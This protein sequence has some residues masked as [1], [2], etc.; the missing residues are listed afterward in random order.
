MTVNNGDTA[1]TSLCFGAL[2]LRPSNGRGVTTYA[3]ELLPH[4]GP[5]VRGTSLSAVVQADAASEL[6]PNIR[7]EVRPVSTGAKRTWQRFTT[8]ARV[9]VFHGLN[10]DIPVS[11]PNMRVA[12]VHD[13]SVFDIPQAYSRYAVANAR[14]LLRHTMRSADLLITVSKFTADRI[15]ARFGREST[16][17]PLAP[18]SWTKVPDDD[19]VEAVAVKHRL[20]D[21]YLFQFCGVEPRKRTNLAI[22]IARALNMPLILAGP[23]TDTL[24]LPDGVLGLGFVEAA[25][26][27]GL[28]AGATVVTFTSAYEGFGLPPLEAMACGAAVV[29]SSVGGM[30]AVVRDGAVLVHSNDPDVWATAMR[31]IINDDFNSQDIRMRAVRAAEKLSWENTAQATVAAY[32]RAGIVL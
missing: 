12:T 6:P 14:S 10:A 16:V 1:G 3:R 23:G 25:D 17:V 19:E 32:W 22:A 28:C 4:V 2:G 18:A 7:P 5:F 15:K 24:R 27:P 30:P 13:I 20:P 29:T 21:R 8:G 26:L 9:D 31:P 11:G